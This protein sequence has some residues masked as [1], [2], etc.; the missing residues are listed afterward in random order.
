MSTPPQVEPHQPAIVHVPKYERS[1][2]DDAGA[3]L[4]ELD[5]RHMPLHDLVLRHTMA[6]TADNRWVARDVAL[7]CPA[8][9]K[10]RVVSMREVIGAAVLQEKVLHVCRDMLVHQTFERLLKLIESAP[11]LSGLVSKTHRAHG[12]QGVWFQGGGVIRFSSYGPRVRGR[13]ADLL[14][15]DNASTVSPR[16]EDEVYPTTVAMPNPQLWWVDTENGGPLGWLQGR[17]QIATGPQAIYL[18]WSD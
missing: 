8:E 12:D 17:A 2:G 18:E 5:V 7:V 14:V 16:T 15:L 10:Q 13:S 3:V 4:D 1:L 6:V 9:E 11:A